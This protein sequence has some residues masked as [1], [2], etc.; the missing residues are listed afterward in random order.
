MPSKVFPIKALDHLTIFM[1]LSK[2]PQA[3]RVPRL[4]CYIQGTATMRDSFSTVIRRNSGGHSF[5]YSTATNDPRSITGVKAV[6]PF[7]GQ[8]CYCLA[9]VAT[10]A[11][12][13]YLCLN[14]CSGGQERPLGSNRT[15][16][17]PK[18]VPGTCPCYHIGGWLAPLL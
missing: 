13:H 18:R 8:S 5:R 9:R 4:Y 10:D 3:I 17:S 11:V 2:V 14:S 16:M 1:G 6:I 12:F 15:S 7:R